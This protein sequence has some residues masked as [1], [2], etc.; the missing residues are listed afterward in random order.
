M[1]LRDRWLHDSGGLVWHARALRWRKSLWSPFGS[2]VAQWLTRW[3]P[4][5]EDLLIIGPSAGYTLT[6]DWL[7]RWRTVSA[8]EPDPLARWLLPRRM[9]RSIRFERL[10][11]FAAYGPQQLARAFPRHAIL[12]SNVLGQCAPR[13][14]GA[15][16]WYQELHEALQAH[17]WASYHDVASTTRPPDQAGVRPVAA[18]M[19][20]DTA[21]AQFWRGG[22]LEITDHGCFGLGRPEGG[23]RECA[24]WAL[25]PTQHHL[26]EWCRYTPV[27]A[28]TVNASRGQATPG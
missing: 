13:D 22:E 19:T 6:A 27:A 3:Q 18:G 23:E 8:C 11:F 24:V 20:L 2:V 17:H 25:R 12:F 9:R 10:D 28:L 14:A 4:P 16:D 26:I 7:R 5:L 21:L 1:S 15:A